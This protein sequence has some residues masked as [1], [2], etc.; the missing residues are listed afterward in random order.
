MLKSFLI[1][2]NLKKLYRDPKF[3]GSLGGKERFFKAVKK[4]YPNIKR[5]TVYNYLKS[6]DTYTLHKP[7]VK[8]KKFRRVYTKGISYLY[9]IDLIDMS[10]HAKQ[11]RGWKWIINCLDTFS[12]KMWCFKLKNKRGKS[13]TDALRS[14]LTAN[15]PQKIETDGGTEFL[16]SH[17]RALLNR[18]KI[19]TYQV[20]GPRKNC[21]VERSNLTLKRRMYK[22][23]TSRGSHVW[24]DILQDLVSGYNNS[25]HGS[26]KMTPNEVNSSNESEV[27]RNLFPPETRPKPAKFKVGDSVR[28]TRKKTPW[29]KGYEM[30]WSYEVF[31]ISEIKLTNPRTYSIKDYSSQAIKGIFYSQELQL[32]DTSS[33]IYPIEKIIRRRKSRGRFQYLVKYIGYPDIYNSWVDQQDL[34]D[35]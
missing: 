27:R 32:I 28:I 29:Q 30:G 2:V 8:P 11:N 21:I 5:S 6:D 31:Y 34:F 35:L 12:K 7:V 24:Y 3:E 9:Q 16:N 4:Q 19:K 1:M 20:F 14:L 22:A 33:D 23:F 17:F 13:V 26:I 25:Y 10:A 18:L 15:R